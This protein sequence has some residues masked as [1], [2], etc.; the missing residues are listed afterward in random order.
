[1]AFPLVKAYVFACHEGM[2]NIIAALVISVGFALPKASD[3]YAYPVQK[4]SVKGLADIKIIGVRGKLKLQGQSRAK[5]LSLKVQHSRSRKYD[6]WHLSVERRGKTLFLEVFNVAY[7]KQWK[8]QVREELWPEFD[9]ELSGSSLPASV[10]WREGTLQFLNWSAD[11]DVSFLKGEA[12]VIGG[13]GALTLQPV[14]A[15]VEI[16]ARTGKVA[17]L[18]ES[19][20]VQLSGNHGDL[21]LN[22]LSGKIALLNCRGKLRVESRN[23]EL[24]VN[25]GQGEFEMLLGQGH[26]RIGGFAGTILGKG[27]EAKWDFVGSAPLDLNITTSSG[28]VGVEWK[29][30]GAKVF[31][32]SQRGPI[33]FK[34]G[35][36]LKVGDREGHKVVEGVKMAKSMGQVFIRTESGMIRWQ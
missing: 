33:Q 6:D 15:N 25:G 16:R 9:I 30:G 20:V 7:G 17:V 23:S 29:N 10:G 5:F 22:W 11:L 31:L 24:S 27:D 3:M 35:K 28:P 2:W 13:T 36:F 21:N 14:Q 18:G 19:G 4:I 26:A 8:N 32:T 1:M 34:P 12:K